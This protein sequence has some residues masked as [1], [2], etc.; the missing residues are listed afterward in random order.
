M[1]QYKYTQKIVFFFENL[2]TI[3]E[4]LICQKVFDLYGKKII[5]QVFTGK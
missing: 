4:E 2:F 1:F 5:I 3:T